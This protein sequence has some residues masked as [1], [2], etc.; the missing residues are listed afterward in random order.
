M[1][2]RMGRNMRKGRDKGDEKGKDRSS[3]IRRK[4]G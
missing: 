4:H 2:Q 3:R 1:K